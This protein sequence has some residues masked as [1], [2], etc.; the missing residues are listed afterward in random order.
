MISPQTIN[1]LKDWGQLISYFIAVPVAVG[2][3][4]KAIYEIQQSRK[5]RADELRWKRANAAKE[6]LDDMHSDQLAK[7]AIHM[8][9]WCDGKDVYEIPPEK[10]TVTIS[11]SDVLGALTDN[12]PKQPKLFEVY[13]RDCFDWFF[14]RVERLEHY[15]RRGLI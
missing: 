9:D 8:P 11:Y 6:L 1:T 7:R 14:Y 12:P 15:I 3:L 2:G 5:Q 13:I 10:Q 4:V